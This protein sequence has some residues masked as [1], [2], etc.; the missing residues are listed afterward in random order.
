MAGMLS[1]GHQVHGCGPRSVAAFQTAGS[2]SSLLS[3]ASHRTCG[4]P[5]PFQPTKAAGLGSARR[6]VR[7]LLGYK[8]GAS[9]RRGSSLVVH[10]ERD[11]YGILGVSR[12]ADKKTIKSAYRQLARKWHPDVN[13]E[14]GAEDKFKDISAAYEVLS[15]DNKKSVYDRFGEAGLQGG[16]GRPGGAGFES[17][18]FDIFESFFGGMGGGNPFSDAFGGGG[19]R[20]QARDPR[21]PGD[22]RGFG[23]QLDFMEA[24]F[25]CNKEL[26]ISHLESCGT[27]SGSGV[28][29][30][31]TPTTCKTCGGQGQV[32]QAVRTPLGMF[33]QVASCPTCGGSGQE[34]TPCGTCG[35]DGRVRAKK[36]ISLRVPPGI[37]SG[38]RLRVRGEG[39]AGKRGGEPGD[40]Y[41]M[42]T[43]KEHPTLRREG[44]TI[45]SDVRVPYTDAI[46]G[47]SVSVTTV[48]GDVDLKVP[49]GTQPGTTLVMAK[50]GVPKLG[51]AGVRGD[52]LVHVQVSIP[53][54]LSGEEQRLVEQLAELSSKESGKKSGAKAG[55]FG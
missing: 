12:D 13:K 17:N 54:T 45:H 24:V 25:G 4:T 1:L 53:K 8:R 43:V 6:H 42:L 19:G 37:D 51:K 30:G 32:V 33:Q 41:V 20:G 22:D 23:L 9:Q 48:D 28:K 15:D 40:L 21:V 35:G 47:A 55:W 3:P 16:G 5:H 2:R 39:D 29:A 26:D 44:Q 52:H 46:L 11:F 31:T 49:A 36:R 14:A 18:P 34:S 27:C 50:R 7:G 38:S 10:A